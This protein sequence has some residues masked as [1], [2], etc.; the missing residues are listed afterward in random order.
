MV[1]TVAERSLSAEFRKTSHLCRR[2]PGRRWWTACDEGARE[3]T[4]RSAVR[5]KRI[6]GASV[7]AMI[8]VLKNR[9]TWSAS[10]NKVMPYVTEDTMEAHILCDL[11]PHAGGQLIHQR[12]ELIGRDF[13][14]SFLKH[15]VKEYWRLNSILYKLIKDESEK[16]F[17]RCVWQTFIM[18]FTALT[19]AFSSQSEARRNTQVSCSSP[20]SRHSM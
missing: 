9:I 1:T 8:R 7:L 10:A 18:S 4:G 17:F 15:R 16:M 3:T 2:S 20:C 13:L 6:S 14:H 12:Q 5:K 19:S 11:G